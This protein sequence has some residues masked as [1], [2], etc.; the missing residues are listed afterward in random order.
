MDITT[1]Y[2]MDYNPFT[3]EID[4]QNIFESD[5][6]RQM[7]NRLEFIIKTKGIGMFL[8][9]PG[10]GK[11]TC[12][13]SVLQKLNPNRYRVYYICMTTITALDFYRMLNEQLGLE[14]TTQKTKMFN[15]IQNE[16]KRLVSDNKTEVI[17]AIDE[18]QYLKPEV[19]REFIMLMNFDYDSKDYCTLILTGQNDFLKNLRKKSLEPLKQRIN[20]NYI[21]TGMNEKQVGE[22]IKTRLAMVNCRNDLF[23][24]ESYH[25]LYTLMNTSVRTLNQLIVKSMIL[26]M[27]RNAATITSEIIMDASEEVI[28]S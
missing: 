15:Q 8:S 20:V 18:A 14:E 2:G 26:G 7:S 17:I 21:F 13:R 10:M 1:Y 23:S 3:K 25:T 5:D 28:I 22:Y 16:L 4:S 27:N 12:L 24:P 19:L 6:C 11:T 9:N